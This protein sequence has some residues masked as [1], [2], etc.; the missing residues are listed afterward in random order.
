M[1]LQ[2]K[3]LIYKI[4]I[5]GENFDS[6]KEIRLKYLTEVSGQYYS[7]SLGTDFSVKLNTLNGYEIVSQIWDIKPNEKYA[8]LRENY[9]TGTCGLIVTF[10]LNDI[11]SF[12]RMPYW[13]NDIYSNPNISQ[14]KLPILI[15][16]IKTANTEQVISDKKIKEYIDQL[17]DWL[18]LEVK[19]LIIDETGEEI[20]YPKDIKFKKLYHEYLMQIITIREKKLIPR[21]TPPEPELN[22]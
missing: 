5:L 6:R 16:G 15:I 11:D 21:K 2:K 17:S 1:K 18:S 14:V 19:Y 7:S 13:I 4:T 8:A 12:K 20:Y 22:N 10:N 3:R 9:Y